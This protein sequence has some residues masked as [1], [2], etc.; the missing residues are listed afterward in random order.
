MPAAVSVV[1][2]AER[3]DHPQVLPLLGELDRYLAGLYAPEDNHILGVP[4]LLAPEVDFLAAWK[5]GTAVGCA[6]V[7]RASDGEG[8]YGEI[9][10]MF[11]AP[12]ARGARIGE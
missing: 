6:A 3:P 1:V 12:E 5:D 9:K 2:R 11:V 7:R 10:R 4:E 8:R